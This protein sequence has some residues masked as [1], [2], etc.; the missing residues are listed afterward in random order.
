MQ[1]DRKKDD[2]EN[3]NRKNMKTW[4][5]ERESKNEEETKK[6]KKKAKGT[7]TGQ[8]ARKEEQDSVIN[9]TERCKRK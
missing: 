7:G 5:G 9:S 4:C 1:E 6:K 8:I 2:T 3:G